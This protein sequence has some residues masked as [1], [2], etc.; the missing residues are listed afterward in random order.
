MKLLVYGAT[1]HIGSR[2]VAEAAQ[3]GHEVV[4]AS[5]SGAAGSVRTDVLDATSVAEL[6]RG[7][8]AI[9]SAVG[10]GIASG[11]AA[12]D[13]DIYVYAARSLI[14]AVRSLGAEG[15]RV[16]VVGGAG[17]LHVAPGVRAVDSPGFPEQFKPDALAQAAA[18]AR[19][20][21]VADVDWT[22]ISP[23]GT[24]V[25]GERTGAYRRGGDDMLVDAAGVSTISIEDYAV[26]LVDELER[27]AATRTRI[28]VAY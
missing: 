15:P 14:E 16:I 4:A 18:L 26:A 24:I 7:Q 8:Q 28:T 6:A 13:Y 25:P 9:V 2:I 10:S 1:G 27:P 3:R 12:P 5:R 21:A 17:S 20:R 19:W 22:Y 23:A 11:A